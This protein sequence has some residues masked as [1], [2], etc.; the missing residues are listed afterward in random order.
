LALA[1]VQASLGGGEEV[2]FLMFAKRDDLVSAS[3]GAG[4][5]L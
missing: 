4:R 2:L 1:R 5:Y 3:R